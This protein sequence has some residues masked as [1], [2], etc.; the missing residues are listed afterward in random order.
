MVTIKISNRTAYT[1]LAVVL[2]I[3]MGGLVYAVAGVSHDVT[4]LTGVCSLA[5]PENCP[6]IATG[7]ITYLEPASSYSYKACLPTCNAEIR[8]ASSEEVFNCTMYND[9]VSYEGYNHCS[10][11]GRVLCGSDTKTDPENPFRTITVYYCA[12][13][14]T[15]NLQQ[16]GEQFV[17]N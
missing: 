1:F 3:L 7:N 9:T 4:E 10:R 15:I 13:N 17:S 2:I 12:K 11:Y 8:F 6:I 16:V 14:N 5:H